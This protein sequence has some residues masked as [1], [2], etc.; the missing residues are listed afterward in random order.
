MVR[1]AVHLLAHVA[2]PAVVARVAWRERWPKAWLVMIATMIV[3][4][5]H[6]LARP[7]FDPQ[8]CSIG[9]HPFHSYPAIALYA[10]VS[11]FPATRWIGVGLLLHM[12][13]DAL[14]CVAMRWC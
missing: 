2:V 8:R 9:F 4:L 6:L 12:A 3:D 11:F 14:D 13:L 1:M 5:D 7:L 10:V